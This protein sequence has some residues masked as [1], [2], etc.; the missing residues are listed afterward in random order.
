MIQQRGQ[1]R[2]LPA[3]LRWW[4]LIRRWM[5]GATPKC[6]MPLPIKLI[7]HCLA[8]GSWH[9]TTI[10][11]RNWPK[12][13]KFKWFRWRTVI[14]AWFTWVVHE[15]WSWRPRKGTDTIWSRWWWIPMC[16][17]P[18]SAYIVCWSRRLGA[19]LMP[20]WIISIRS[21]LPIIL[22]FICCLSIRSYARPLWVATSIAAARISLFWI[23]PISFFIIMVTLV[24]VIISSVVSW[25]WVSVL[26]WNLLKKKS[27]R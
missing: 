14:C 22:V 10:S 15:I 13:T 4:W 6:N 20:V 27:N 2:V 23:Y 17:V 16:H 19:C 5:R 11:C 7:G 26:K 8:S 9:V 21:P 12:W 18:W 1:K 25:A 3:S 24:S